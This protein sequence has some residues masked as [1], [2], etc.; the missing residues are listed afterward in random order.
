MID[1]SDLEGR[2]HLTRRIEDLRAGL[3]GRLEGEA[4]WLRDADGLRQ[5]E[6]G[7]LHYGSA[8]PMQA[9][10]VYLWRAEQD[11]LIVL[12]EDGRPFHRLRPGSVSGPV[13]DRHLCPPDVYDV[14]YTFEAW[15]VWEQHWHV[16]G[17]RKDARITSRF[18]PR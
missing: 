8:P 14:R 15:P 18:T 16:T 7:L 9:S 17:P 5:E 1:L 4:I 13:A 12:F 10:R 11:G 2:W 3:S 6:R